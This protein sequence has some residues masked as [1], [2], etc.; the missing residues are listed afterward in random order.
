MIS[1]S[2]KQPAMTYIRIHMRISGKFRP[3]SFVFAISNQTLIDL[4]T[5]ERMNYYP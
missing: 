5:I 4:L 3:S 1:S 2:D